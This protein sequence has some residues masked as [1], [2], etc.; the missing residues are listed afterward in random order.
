MAN[1]ETIIPNTHSI[2][3]VYSYSADCTKW[4]MSPNSLP[5]PNELEKK[6][7]AAPKRRELSA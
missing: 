2:V 7:L 3:I 6:P 4:T 1:L 5:T